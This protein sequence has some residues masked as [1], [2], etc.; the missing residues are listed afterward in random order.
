VRALLLALMLL[1][2]TSATAQ[3]TT[4][5]LTGMSESP[6][7]G[8]PLFASGYPI[9][10]YWHDQRMEVIYL[11]SELAAAGLTPG[12]TIT[13]M[14]LRCAEVPGQPQVMDFRIRVQHTTMTTV[15][16]T[17][18]STGWTLC[19]G[20]TSIPQAS[21]SV[22]NWTAMPF[23]N[24]FLWDGT[25]NLYVCFST[26]GIAWTSG[27][28]CFVR[29]TGT[30]RARHYY[31]DS[32]QAWPYEVNPLTYVGTLV[33]SLRID[34]LPGGPGFEVSA[35]AGAAQ[36]VYT[37]ARG[38][39]NDGLQVGTFDVTANFLPGATLSSIEIEASGTG[40]DSN[41]FLD[42]AI[43]Y[44]DPVLGTQGTFDPGIDTQVGTYNNFVV[45]D[46]KARFF[47]Q[48]ALQEFAPNETKTFFVVVRLAGTASP[49][50]TFNFSVSELT[51]S[52]LTAY[53]IGTPSTVMNGLIIDAP[54]FEF[55]DASP[56]VAQTV[57]LGGRAVCQTFD[58]EYLGGPD[59]KPSSITITGLGTADEV[60]DLVSVQLWYDSDNTGTFNA[61]TDTLVDTTS[62]N[63]PNGTAT[64][65]LTSHPKFEAS[66]LRRFF[67]VYNL[68]FSANN[69]DTFK[70]YVSA[71]GTSAFGGVAV[72]LPIPGTNGTQ[73]LEVSANVLTG[74]MIGPNAPD[75]VHSNTVGAT[76]NGVLLAD[77]TLGAGPGGNWNVTGLT[78]NASPATT[79]GNHNTAFTAVD[80]WISSS[81]GPWDP[82]TDQLASAPSNF[83]SDV[84]NFTIPTAQL[85]AGTSTR[86]FLVGRMNGTAA[87]GQT[88]GANLASVTAT[89]DIPGGVQNGIP[90]PHSSA[91]LIDA[92]ALVVA[93]AA[94]Q[95]PEVWHN[96]GSARHHVVGKFELTALNSDVT[97][98]GFVLTAGGTGDWSSDV[99]PLSGVEVYRDNGDGAFDSGVDTLIFQGGGGSTINVQFNTA[100]HMPITSKELLWVRIGLTSSAGMGQSQVPETFTLQIADVNDVAASAPAIMGMDLPVA[101]PLGAIEFRVDNFDPTRD[102]P[103]GGRAITIT[104]SG[105]VTPVRVLIAGVVCPGS[106]VISPDGMTITNITVPP[107]T[108]GGETR[109]LPIV[110]ES[111]KLP[112]QTL[113]QTFEY[114]TS[115]GDSSS[116]GGG[117]CSS[118]SGS[119]WPLLAG[120]FAL[121][122]IGATRVA[123]R[124][125]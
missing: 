20:P 33:P 48:P 18:T 2:G 58:I 96:A 37:T 115:D 47:V 13:G 112:P 62:F 75:V 90:T 74:T 16:A 15:P 111:G 59:D 88:F 72:G 5:L 108:T 7:P 104:G 91:L 95:A 23:T 10:T 125:A 28:G 65:Q 68:N 21:F 27:G 44:D 89:P 87:F 11:A 26:D 73:G 24:T 98:N 54:E 40:N 97:V 61:Q 25:S 67:V 117:G 82:L 55:T 42:V 45:N 66:D 85:A 120:M 84:V 70:C 57:F 3:L 6:A 19:Y 17:F 43:Y 102:R 106:P 35:A 41:A 81:G 4:E 53:S 60:A 99:D 9:S 77:F 113:A 101:T 36:N 105:F 118:G 94:G 103:L 100:I 114:R 49:G 71:M 56:A 124:R 51:Y 39:G 92:A 93:N 122:A 121:L 29:Q 8:L 69:N 22:N 38:P 86:F 46:G 78:L 63:A 116:G 110:V 50:D 119:P 30:Q 79:S 107:V 52:G 12:A 123:R 76:G 80:L 34:Y 31:S 14:Q 32:G 83:V 1:C 109:N 64:F